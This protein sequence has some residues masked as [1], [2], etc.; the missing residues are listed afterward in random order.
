MKNIFLL[1]L[2]F[3]QMALGQ[4]LK[5]SQ[6]T[7]LTSA[8]IASN[9]LTLISDMSAS[10]SK[11]VSFAELDSRW[12]STALAD[13]YILVGNASGTATARAMSGDASLSNLGIITFAN[14]GVISGSYPYVTVDSKGRVTGASQTVSGATIVSSTFSGGTVS[15]SSIVGAGLTGVTFT[16]T[17]NNGGILTGG[18]V[19]G[20]GIVV[21]D[22]VL[23]IQDDST[24]TKKAQFQLSSITAGQTRTYSWPDNSGTV[25]L[26]NQLQTFSVSQTFSGGL[27]VSSGYLA[28]DSGSI[29]FPAT[30]NP[31]S[32]AN[33]FDDYEEGTFTPTYFGGSTAGSTSYTVQAAT[34]TK[35]GNV[36]CV[37]VRVTWTAQTGTG[38]PRWGGLPF[39]IKNTSNSY[40]LGIYYL[41]NFSFTA[42]N[43]PWFYP[44]P[45]T[46][47]ATM[48]QMPVGGGAVTNAARDTAA[49]L[50]YGGCYIASQ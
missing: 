30:Q 41:E 15:G 18:T 28:V 22:N 16:G 40:L 32:G 24:P 1:I 7:P 38:D 43:T 20:S 17:N 29:K 46:T 25:A 47:T 34:Y 5:L 19:S 48:Y 14:T 10:Q 35:F 45:N 9:D 39:T 11:S 49:D 21:N 37:G 23:T 33:D 42:S 3:A 4:N 26:L 8:N 36:V 12:Q 50:G 31:S 6:L 27:T 13:S 44:I 2:L